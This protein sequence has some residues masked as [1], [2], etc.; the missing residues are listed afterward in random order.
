MSVYIRPTDLNQALAALAAQPL[1]IVAGATD[2]YPAH[3]GRPLDD[4]ILDIT[5]IEDLRGIH[6]RG[7]HW[8]LGATTT[9]TDLIE[10]DLPPCFDGLC[11]AARE[12]G[13][14]QIQNRATVA[15]N[16]CNAS[17]AAD[18]VPPLLTLQA[19]VELSHAG[20]RRELPLDDFIT[21]NRRTAREAGELLSAVLIPKPAA[22]ARSGFLKLGA[23]R[24]LVIS[25]VSVA[26]L[27]EVD[28]DSRVAVARLAVGSCSEV[29]QRL[30]ALEAALAGRPANAG[31]ADGLRPEHL[32]PL[33]PIGD[34]RGSA[35]YR[36]DAAGTMVARLL[37][38]LG[39]GA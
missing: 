4:D 32:D 33:A 9:W 5:A 37:A 22:G 34:C 2:V 18:G 30:P 36:G 38:Q 29:A 24:Y 20:G 21:G 19:R 35:A 14:E 8:R 12:V 25:I 31:L 23:R 27:L 13:G 1:T 7:D 17:P 15:G 11:L 26:G 3:V 39:A 16:L 10:A 6:D 28:D